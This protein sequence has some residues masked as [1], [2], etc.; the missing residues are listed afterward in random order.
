MIQYKSIWKHIVERL[1]NVGK[2]ISNI[3]IHPIQMTP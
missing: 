3:D 2:G 1:E